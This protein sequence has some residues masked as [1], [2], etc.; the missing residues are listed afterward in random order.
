MRPYFVAVS[1]IAILSAAACAK[2]WQPATPDPAVL[3]EGTWMLGLVNDLPLPAN[4]DGGVCWMAPT[5]FDRADW[6]G[7]AVAG[8]LTLG[9][10][11]L[12]RLEFTYS[13]ECPNPSGPVPVQETTVTASGTW[14]ALTEIAPTLGEVQFDAGQVSVPGGVSRLGWTNGTLNFSMVVLTGGVPTIV[15]THFWR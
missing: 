1:A 2:Q 9:H 7:K 5:G 8:S 12:A 13:S 15:R 6:I 14:R 10:D 4:Y 3:F 11:G